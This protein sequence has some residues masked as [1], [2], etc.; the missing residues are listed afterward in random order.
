MSSLLYSLYALIY[1]VLLVW[2]VRLLARTRRPGTGFIALVIF[3]LL[4]DNLILSLGNWTGAGDFLHRLSYWRFVFHQ[5]FLPWIMVAAYQQAALAGHPWAGRSWL[6]I[7]VWVAALAIMGIGLA[8]RVYGLRLEPIVM[9]GVTRYVAVGLS[10]P[11]VVSIVSILFAGVMGFLLWRQ[12]NWP[13]TLAAAILVFI[14]EGAPVE[15][16]RRLAG[17]GVEVL[18]MVALLKIEARLAVMGGTL[19]GARPGLPG[20]PPARVNP[21]PHTRSPAQDPAREQNHAEGPQ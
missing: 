7:G 2:A 11:P 12:L 19:P 14:V 5:L 17:S 6:R 13:W 16:L 3:G 9:D 10:G 20:I 8:T 1:L 15:A 4:Y 18:F 21:F